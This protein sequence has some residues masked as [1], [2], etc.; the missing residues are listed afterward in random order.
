MKL[1]KE[2]VYKRQLEGQRG[3]PRG[4]MDAFVDLIMRVSHLLWEYP[5]IRELDINPVR[6]FFDRGGA[7]ALD[8]R[9]RIICSGSFNRAADP[10]K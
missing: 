7:M 8:A 3:N 10:Q 4:D 5:H 6:V 2:D 9:A 1:F